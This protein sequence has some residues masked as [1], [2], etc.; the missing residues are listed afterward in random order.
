[1]LPC[2]GQLSR[3]VAKRKKSPG[4]VTKVAGEA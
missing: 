1:M 3:S 2:S 4:E